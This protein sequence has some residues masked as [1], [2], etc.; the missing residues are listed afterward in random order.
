MGAL[1]FIG[2][3]LLAGALLL[4]IA[5]KLV[6]E[7]GLIAVAMLA[8]VAIASFW[9]SAAVGAAAFFGLF[10]L[11]GQDHTGWALVGA[12]LIGA[13]VWVGVIRGIWREVASSPQRWRRFEVSGSRIAACLGSLLSFPESS[14]SRLP[15]R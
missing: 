1:I 8:G 14:G 2:V 12:L 5:A 3:A 6:V 10:E 7:V 13:V 9:L 11:L 15:N 4:G